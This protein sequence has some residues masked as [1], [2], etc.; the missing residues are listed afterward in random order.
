[1][2]TYGYIRVSSREQNEARQRA[3]LGEWGITPEEMVIDRQSGK[4]FQR[5]GWRR[6]MK[7][8]RPGDLLVVQSIDRLGRNYEEILEQWRWITKERRADVLVLDMPLLDTR[9]KGKDLTGTFIADLVLQIL[10]YVAQTERE[11]IRRRQAEGIA[12]A[13]A[14][15]V[16][17]GAPGKPLPPGFAEVQRAYLEGSISLKTALGQTG[18]SPSTFCRK[19]KGLPLAGG[20]REREKGREGGKK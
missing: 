19:V 14:R 1:M 7:R 2:A 5:P 13:K 12:A 4:D 8:L 18:M 11:N 15:G 6:L 16:R 3:A 20:H 10:S 9:A 17:F